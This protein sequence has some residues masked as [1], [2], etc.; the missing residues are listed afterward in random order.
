MDALECI[1]TR[2]TVRK[3]KDE[4]IPQETL[5][6][7][8]SAASFSPAW[9]NTRVAR[10]TVIT[11]RAAIARI[12]AQGVLGNAHNAG[13]INGAHCLI[14]QSAVNKLA[15]YEK[16]VTPSTVKG[17][18]YTMYDCGISAQSLSLAAH[19]LGLGSVIMGIIDYDTIA[20]IIALPED[21][22]VTAAIAVGYPESIPACPPKYTVDEMAR[23]I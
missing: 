9:K 12:A 6:E 11:D 16:D 2:R 15:G 10:Y 13:I 23:F 17:D 21:E 1:K 7:L 4:A 20:S 8:I 14:V 19:A 5:R 3:F 18:G 22:T